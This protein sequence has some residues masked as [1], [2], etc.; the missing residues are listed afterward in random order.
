[1]QLTK[2][3]IGLF[4][5]PVMFIIILQFFHPEGLS[6]AANAVLASAVWVAI[7]WITEALPIAVTALLP[8]V[9]FPL[10]GGLSLKETTASYGHKYIFLFVGGF[11]LAIAIEKWKLHK[12]IALTIIKVV[13]TNVV[14]II[15]GFM[16]ATAFLSMWISNTATAVMI[17]P[18]GMAI[19]AQLKDN[20]A[21]IEDE[22]IIF[23]KA[24]MLAIA[25]SAS[26]GGMATLIGTPPNLV[27]AGVVEETY[28]IEITF[29]QWFSFGF[30]ITL[31]LLT[32]CWLYLT[33]FAFKFKQKTFPGGRDEIN[34]QLKV[35]GKVS[36]EEKT[37]LVVFALTAFAWITRSFLIKQFV[38]AIDDTI[39]AIMFSIL[40]FILPSKEKH[41]K[42]IAWEDAVKLPWGILLLFGGGMA[43]ALGF[44]SSGLALWL[45]GQ[46]TNLETL[47]LFSLLFV[48]I[49]AVNFLTEITSNLATTAMLLPVLAPLATILN[50]HPYFLMVGA[51][52]AASCAFMLPVA[53]PPNAVVFGSGYLKIEDMVK[54]GVWMNIISIILL[55]FIVYYILPL[56][57]DLS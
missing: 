15:L 47:S 33:K 53:T 11:I 14:N 24:L 9:L 34:R 42:I 6:E 8:I 49:A 17:L 35:L 45:G 44:D 28:G 19:V 4:S 54:K 39:I 43:L 48:L 32:I 26:I 20:P 36:Y 13:G 18:V 16:I 40:L 21:T 25:Y 2:Q 38:P 1:M 22:N 50:I 52:V 37:V 30:P 12:R 31:L 46:M 57:W 23:G 55:T 51:T 10:S 29:S 3:K 5:G 41:K 7:W 56:L 27:L